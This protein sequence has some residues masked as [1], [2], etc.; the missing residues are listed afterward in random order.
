MYTLINESN[1]DIKLVHLG[2]KKNK[3]KNQNLLPLEETN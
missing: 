2:K 1:A 3:I